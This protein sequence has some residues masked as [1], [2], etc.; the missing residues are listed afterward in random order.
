LE[1]NDTSH[2]VFSVGC[3]HSCPPRRSHKLVAVRVAVILSPAVKR[4]NLILRASH[5]M[6]TRA[7]RPR[8]YYRVVTCG[9]PH[10]RREMLN[11]S[12][13]K[14]RANSSF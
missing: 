11:R 14:S 12:I 8:G 10:P 13:G 3:G 2:E 1:F 4:S 9:Y 5:Y 6:R 7:T